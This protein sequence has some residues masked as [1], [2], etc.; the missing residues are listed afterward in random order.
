MEEKC[1]KMK[2]NETN[3]VCLKLGNLKLWKRDSLKLSPEMRIFKK[4]KIN[5]QLLLKIKL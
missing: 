3:E 4:R 5:S 2:D 1:G